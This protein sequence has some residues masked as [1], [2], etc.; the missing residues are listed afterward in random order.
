MRVNFPGGGVASPLSSRPQQATSPFARS[1]QAWF[2]PVLSATK[3]PGGGSDCPYE[4]E[5]HVHRDL[6][7]GAR[8]SGNGAPGF[9][10][11]GDFTVRAKSAQLSAETRDV[12]KG[13]S[14]GFAFPPVSSPKH[15][16]V[17]LLRTAQVV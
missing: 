7:E 11:T 9:S 12:R 13:S 1:A 2:G 17:P 16:S 8:Q 15:T 6:R 10:P 14:G 5:P 4:F 3:L